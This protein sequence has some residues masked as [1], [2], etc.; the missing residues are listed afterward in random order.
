MQ[1]RFFAYIIWTALFIIV[2]LE[3]GASGL[4]LL[5]I[6]IIITTIFAQ[7]AAGGLVLANRKFLMDHEAGVSVNSLF[8]NSL[9]ISFV[10]GGIISIALFFGILYMPFDFEIAFNTNYLG[11]IAIAVT[12]L[13]LSELCG[14]ILDGL[15][16]K[17]FK[18]A[19]DIIKVLI[20]LVLVLLFATKNLL[21]EFTALSIWVIATAAAS[22]II[23][24][25]SWFYVGKTIELN[26]SV[27]YKSA[28]NSV[29]YLAL[30]LFDLLLI[31]GDLLLVFI[32]LNIK[33]VGIYLFA[34]MLS[35]L[36]WRFSLSFMNT[37]QPPGN[38]RDVLKSLEPGRLRFGLFSAI[39]ASLFTIVAIL[40]LLYSLN[41]DHFLDIYISFLILIP[42]MI[43]LTIER[44]I[45]SEFYRRD[46]ILL[47]FLLF[48]PAIVLLVFAGKFL[49]DGM[50]IIG[51]ALSM[52]IV[53]ILLAATCI[54]IFKGWRKFK[55]RDLLKFRKSDIKEFTFIN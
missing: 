51:A 11:M 48:F 10:W 26:V 9:F 53:H 16:K 44:L 39:I 38:I 19:I 34:A 27:F 17:Q 7:I 49:M 46:K 2:L 42:G 24:I 12:P 35:G 31:F 33:S 55:I 30:S 32:F 20:I 29:H 54:L 40:I 28:I 13:T 21:S 50:G 47:I 4:G 18:H 6:S 15:N 22:V 23:L 52:S 36:I 37:S 8:G 3:T 45:I 43:A 25:I 1:D 41:I 5:S 14:S